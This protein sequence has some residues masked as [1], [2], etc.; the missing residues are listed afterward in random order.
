M[1]RQSAPP[2]A[3]AG[4]PVRTRVA[5]GA[6]AAVAGLSRRLGRGG[7][8]VVG[9]RATLA[10][11]PHALQHLAAG[12][13]VALV[14]GTNGKTTTTSLLRAA[15]STTGPVVTNLLG[16]NLPPGLAAALAAGPPAAPAALEVDEAWLRRVTDATS[17]RVVVLLNLSRD[18][19]DRN[20]EVRRLSSAWRATFADRPGTTVVAN[21][22]DPLVV[23]GAGASPDVVWVGAGQ[24]W[25]ADAS[26]C[27]NCGSRIVFDTPTT[28]VV[29]RHAAGW[30]CSA[31]DLRRPPLA[32]WIEDGSIVGDGWSVPVH[33]ALPGR[34]NQANA[35]L[36]LTAA[37]RLGAEPGP[38]MEAMAATEEVV[39]RYRTVDVAG[40]DARLLLS[41]NPA[42]W[43]EV[44]DMLAP[45]PGP[46]VVAIN[47]R[48][49]D[50]KDPSWLWDVPFE[51]LAGRRVVAT[52]ERSA[53]LAVRLHYAEVDHVRV[54]D[55]MQAVHEAAR[56]AAEVFAGPGA[57]GRPAIDVVAN[58]TPFQE[59]RQRLGVR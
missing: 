18:Q 51:L 43:L 33:L 37:V 27:P 52:G 56:H 15:L 46:V 19:L 13:A 49:A 34:C 54:P 59:L 57:Q 39:G 28:G 16:A 38:A 12:H 11:D 44:F 36:A 41:K 17:P 4:L 24:P 6:G 30:A 50:G 20:N 32:V 58:Y 47:A 14:S 55:V 5:A 1:T 53:D 8:S 23:W 25:T 48:I 10:I 29:D 35:A 2:P 31:C 42:G 3:P 7:G 40:V 22:D 45:P 26:G 21:A 9:G